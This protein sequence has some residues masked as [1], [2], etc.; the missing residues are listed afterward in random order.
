[1]IG[2]FHRR[3]VRVFFPVIPW[4]TGTRQKGRTLAEAGARLMK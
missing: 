4:D 3:G 1:M 2:D